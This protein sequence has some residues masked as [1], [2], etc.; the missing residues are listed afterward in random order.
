MH[1][2]GI[3]IPCY[4]ASGLIN[5]V[6]EKILHITKILKDNYRFNIYII[7]DF[8]PEQSWKEVKRN[9]LIKIL[10][11][12]RNKGVGASTITGFKKALSDKCEVFFKIDADGQH[13]PIYLKELIPYVFSLPNH[14]LVLLKG[15]RYFS[16]KLLSGV[17]FDR[18]L[19]SMFLEPIARAAL[20]YRKLTD[21]ANGYLALNLNTLEHLL[22]IEIGENLESRY[23]FESSILEKCSVLNCEIHE[24]AMASNYPKE[25][26]TSMKSF[27]LIIPLI[28]FWIKAVLKRMSNNYLLS[29]NLG[30]SFLILSLSSLSFALNLFFRRIY[31]DIS[32]GILVSAGTSTAFTSSITIFLFSFCLFLFYDYNSGKIVKKIRF[33]SLIEDLKKK[34]I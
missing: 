33:R 17:P 34:I 22:S 31:S 32:S 5:K 7:D 11:H 26:K 15:T 14:K 19:G 20:S 23:L 21:I 29:L 9:K 16:P 3:V 25:W 28:F 8:C 27:Q 6:V 30:S 1:K 12:T 2:V 13:N 10:K 24:F 4:R 18:R